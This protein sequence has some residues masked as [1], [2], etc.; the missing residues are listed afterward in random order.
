MRT[1]ITLVVETDDGVYP[2]PVAAM[3]AR[4]GDAIP[5]TGRIRCVEFVVEI[6]EA[7][8]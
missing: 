6:E 3:A 7:S 4:F 1:R 5:D 2:D 8:P